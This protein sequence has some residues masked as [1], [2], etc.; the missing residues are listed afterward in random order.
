M[1]GHFRWTLRGSEPSR[2]RLTL[3][4]TVNREG[5]ASTGGAPVILE[6]AQGGEGV[7]NL[8]QEIGQLLGHQRLARNHRLAHEG[9]L[10]AHA[11]A[12][13]KAVNPAA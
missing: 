11:R 10:L 2:Y 4:F 5:L 3:D 1:R 13:V 7:V 12:G 6:Q 8:A 9:L